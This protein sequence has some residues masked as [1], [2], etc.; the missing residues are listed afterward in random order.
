VLFDFPD[1][2]GGR[3][4]AVPRLPVEPAPREAR[5]PVPHR[6]F[7]LFYQVEIRHRHSANDI[8]RRLG[9]PVL[10]QV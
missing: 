1:Y 2:N 10:V 6:L 5:A 9:L 7:H 8:P 4:A 3:C